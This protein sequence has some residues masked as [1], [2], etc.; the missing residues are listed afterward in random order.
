M[1]LLARFPLYVTRFLPLVSCTVFFLFASAL[2]A[3]GQINS[4]QQCI[5]AFQMAD[6][7]SA[8]ELC[9]RTAEDEQAPRES[10]V[11]ALQYL[12]RIYAAKRMNEKAQDAIA[13][14]LELEPPPIEPDPDIEPIAYLKQYYQVRKEVCEC[15]TVE[16]DPGL[17]TMAIIDFLN[18]SIDEADRFDPLRLGIASMLIN[19]LNGATGL[20]VVERERLNW[21]LEEIKL[22]QGDL[23]NPSARVRPGELLGATTMLTGGFMVQGRNM[24]IWARLDKV[25]TGEVLLAETVEGSTRRISDLLE[26]LSLQVA[27]AINVALDENE[28]GPRTETNSLDAMLSYAEGLELEQKGDFHGAFEKFQEALEY[29][30]HYTRARLKAQ[31]AGLMLAA[32]GDG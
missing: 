18:S 9:S 26:K 31:S 30:E 6:F 8:T 13:R 23:V 4:L 1:S 21:L 32:A 17:Q 7:E 15:Y 22:N 2:P 28:I 5:E 11:E 27:R 29:D 12:G 3:T 25:E 19:Y 20:K 16:H 10:R 14:L 24:T